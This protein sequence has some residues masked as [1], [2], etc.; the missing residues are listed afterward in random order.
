MTYT[1][2]LEDRLAAARYER[3]RYWRDPEYRLKRINHTRALRGAPLI[4]SLDEMSAPK[5][6]LV[7]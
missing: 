1:M 3:E 6:R 7:P 4:R 5:G 2:P